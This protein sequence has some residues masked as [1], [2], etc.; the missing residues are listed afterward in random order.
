MFL[1]ILY[2]FYYLYKNFEWDERSNIV[3][4]KS[5][6]TLFMRLEV[7]VSYENLFS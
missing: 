7:V 4:K 2:L 6:M 3:C 1:I 5:K